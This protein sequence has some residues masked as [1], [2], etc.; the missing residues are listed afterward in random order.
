[1]QWLQPT[2]CYP[3]S[4]L[5][6]EGIPRCVKVTSTCR[7]NVALSVGVAHNNQTFHSMDTLQAF[8]LPRVH[9]YLHIMFQILIHFIADLLRAAF[10]CARDPE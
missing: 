6:F 1:M 2:S 4:S 8:C 7:A 9:Q 10:A 5:G 3:S